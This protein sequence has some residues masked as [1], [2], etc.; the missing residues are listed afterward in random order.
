MLLHAYGLDLNIKNSRLEL[1]GKAVIVDRNVLN[2]YRVFSSVVSVDAS[3]CQSSYLS[4]CY[5]VL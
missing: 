4:N 3:S 1:I 2:T 5:L